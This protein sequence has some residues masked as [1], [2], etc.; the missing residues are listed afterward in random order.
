MISKLNFVMEEWMLIIGYI[1]DIKISAFNAYSFT[2]G[3]FIEGST[4]EPV[5]LTEGSHKLEMISGS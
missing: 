3:M 4:Y 1:D 2:P 5:T